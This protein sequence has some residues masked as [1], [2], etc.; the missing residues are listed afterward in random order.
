MAKETE[1][2]FSVKISAYCRETLHRAIW[3]SPNGFVAVY[4]H[5]DDCEIA[6]KRLAAA[7]GCLGL[8]QAGTIDLGEVHSYAELLRI[9]TS[10]CEPLRIFEAGSAGDAVVA[11]VERPLFLS[12]DQTLIAQ[13]VMLL[14][15]RVRLA[16]Q[17][18]ASVEGEQEEGE[19]RR[20]PVPKAGKKRF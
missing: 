18:V 3:K 15:H 6:R 13:W 20:R 5:A 17:A 8:D 19:E 11:W 12:I 7:L 14:M 4:V 10:E 1:N 2:R 9:G 16:A